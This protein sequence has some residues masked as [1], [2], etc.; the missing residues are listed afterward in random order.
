MSDCQCNL[1]LL[2]TQNT[3]PWLPCTFSEIIVN[4]NQWTNVSLDKMFTGFLYISWHIGEV[5]YRYWKQCLPLTPLL[6]AWSPPQSP[7]DGALEVVWCS[8]P[9]SNCPAELPAAWG[10]ALRPAAAAQCFF[11]SSSS[12]RSHNPLSPALA[13][14]GPEKNVHQW[15]TVMQMFE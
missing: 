12:Q 7:P 1:F 11:A 15:I 4:I 10:W 3:H 9:L 14:T 2:W 8:N 13:Q 5:D 6:G